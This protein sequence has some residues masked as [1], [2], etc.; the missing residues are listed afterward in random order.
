MPITAAYCSHVLGIR[1]PQPADGLQEAVGHATA[2]RPQGATHTRP[3]VWGGNET[4][5]LSDML[6]INFCEIC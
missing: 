2:L 3:Q 1:E 6:I 5:L 4:P